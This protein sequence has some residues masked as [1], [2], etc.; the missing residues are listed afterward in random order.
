MFT[1]GQ[2]SKEQTGAETGMRARRNDTSVLFTLSNLPQLAVDLGKCTLTSTG[3]HGTEDEH[4]GLLDIRS[5]AGTLNRRED[6]GLIEVMALSTNGFPTALTTHSEGPS[7]GSKIA[8]ATALFIGIAAVQTMALSLI[9]KDESL[10]TNIAALRSQITAMCSQ[11]VFK[12][13]PSNKEQGKQLAVAQTAEPKQTPIAKRNK[14]TRTKWAKKA[15]SKASPSKSKK[16]S[17]PSAKVR[18]SRSSSKK[19]KRF[20][21]R[22]LSSKPKNVNP[23]LDYLLGGSSAESSKYNSRVRSPGMAKTSLDRS[24]VHEGMS[25]LARK[26]K[27]CGRGKKGTIMLK[28]VIGRKGNVNSAATTGKFAGTSVGTCAARIV[29]N[30]AKFPA[31]RGNLTVSYPFKL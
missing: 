8:I 16:N 10:T 13:S 6:T 1:K 26:V 25:K 18:R 30:R 9:N 27:R 2:R 24:D 21:R 22:R 7:F 17:K 4:T 20:K 5:L 23:E 14:R 31:S 28:A 19:A 15:Q 29:R 11:G 3:R 12:A